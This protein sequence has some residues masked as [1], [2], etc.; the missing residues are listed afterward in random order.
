MPDVTITY[1]TFL[2]CMYCVSSVIM[3]PKSNSNQTK[4][5]LNA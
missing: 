1:E 3:G 4:L 2:D 5:H